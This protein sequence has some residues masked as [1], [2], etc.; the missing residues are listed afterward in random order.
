MTIR[1]LDHV[2]VVVDDTDTAV[3]LFITLGT[4]EDLT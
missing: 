1:R 2:S 3:G 4:A